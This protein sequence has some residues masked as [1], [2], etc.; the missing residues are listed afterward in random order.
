[1]STAAPPSAGSPGGAPQTADPRAI[2]RTRRRAQAAASAQAS[3]TRPRHGRR[4]LFLVRFA[5]TMSDEDIARLTRTLN[6]DTHLHPKLHNSPSSPGVARL[7]FDS[8]LFLLRN[9]E[10]E[11]WLLEGRTWGDPPSHII[12]EWHLRAIAAARQLDPTVTFPPRAATPSPNSTTRPLGR[13]ANKPLARLGR[14]LLH[15]A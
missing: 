14:R 8:G 3:T 5:T 6:L 13:A 10:D 1:M 9:D 12:H 11:K 7:D 2:G 4:I 15:L